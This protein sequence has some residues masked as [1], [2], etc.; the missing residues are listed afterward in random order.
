MTKKEV[1]RILKKGSGKQKALLYMTDVALANVDLGNLNVSIDADG[2]ITDKGSKLLTAEQRDLLFEGIKEP[3]DVEYYNNLRTYNRAVSMFKPFI[4]ERNIKLR[5]ACILLDAYCFEYLRLDVMTE[6]VNDV[7]SF[8]DNEKIRE[9]ALQKALTLGSDNNKGW[10]G[11][12][13]KVY[14]EESHPEWLDLDQTSG[15][16]RI[17][18]LVLFINTEI[19]QQKYFIEILRGFLDKFIPVYP[20]YD[21]LKEKEILCK[22]AI[23]LNIKL[24]LVTGGKGEGSEVSQIWVYDDIESEVTEDDIMK[25]KIPQ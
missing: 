23:E 7:L 16:E 21:W 3:K 25:I 8:I 11:L 1:N 4:E 20:Y 24:T 17:K 19:A 22:E 18:K 14:Q 15:E 5:W 10:I 2:K 13:G 6:V 12:K 9:E